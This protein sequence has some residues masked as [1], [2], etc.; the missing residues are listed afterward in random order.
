MYAR[1]IIIS[2][3]F[4]LPILIFFLL[5]YSFISKL[6]VNVLLACRGHKFSLACGMQLLV[7]LRFVIGREQ[8][9]LFSRSLFVSCRP[10]N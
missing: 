10:S 1:K 3:V 5:F 8:Q 9:P 2:L 7:L 4:N 6:M